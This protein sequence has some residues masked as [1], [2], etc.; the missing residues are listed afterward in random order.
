M[1]GIEGHP[2]L[3]LQRVPGQLAEDVGDLPLELAHARFAGVGLHELLQGGLLEAHAHV[4]HAMA[5]EGAGQQVLLGDGQ[6]LLGGVAAELQDLEAVLQGLGDLVAHVGRGQ[7]E[8]LAQVEA[9]VQVVVLEGRVLLGI[10]H[11]EQGAAGIA[12][13]I[14]SHLVDLVQQHERIADLGLLHQRNDAAG[15][16]ADV[17]AAVAA[18]LGLVPH[19]TQGQPHE[20][21]VQGPGD[22]AGQRGLAHA[23]RAHQAEDRS[24]EG[25]LACPCHPLRPWPDLSAAGP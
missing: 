12:A 6:L 21:P 3:R 24:A 1:M 20:G 5:F 25:W 9:H 11:L 19:A 2:F 10:Q 14:R 7:E 8:H 4:L 16:G 23:R 17:G 13:E 15:H 22:A 18:D